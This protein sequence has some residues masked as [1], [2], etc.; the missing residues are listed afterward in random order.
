MI[1]DEVGSMLKIALLTAV[2]LLF[3]LIITPFIIAIS[4]FLD[5]KDRP[6]N[7]KVHK[8]PVPT[9][10]G[11]SI[12]I[13]FLLGI[14]ILQPQSDYHLAIMLGA[15]LVI[16]LGFFDDIID[17]PANFKFV[18]QIF[19][20]SFVVFWGGLQVEFVNLPFGGQI[21]FGLLSSVITV[22]WI[23]GVTNAMNLI[24][25]LDGLAAGVSAI[26]L[27]TIAGIAVSMGN[28]Y[29]VTLALV[30]FFSTL[31]FLRYNFFPAK[32]FMGDTGSLFLG[33]MISVLALLGFKSVTIVSFLIPVFILAVPISDTLIAIVRRYVNSQPLSSP[34][35]SHLHHRLLQMGFSHKQTVL[36]IY[37]LSTMFSAAG[38]LF[39]MA[40]LWGGIVIF[41]I[42]MVFLQLLI[43]NLELISSNYKPLTNFLKALKHKL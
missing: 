29:V 13:S 8:N 42:S 21:E 14:T 6:N 15:T 43:E 31:G 36:L 7:R 20:A 34:D 38:I 28:V 33:Y 41:V 11:L 1:G 10:G 32:I 25:G 26:A 17:L 37:A 40:T 9:L 39:S 23:V 18:A 30:L 2:T 19:I 24:D 16:I 35:S 27:F 5:V 3:S 12:F 4:K 22:F